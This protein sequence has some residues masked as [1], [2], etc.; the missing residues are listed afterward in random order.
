MTSSS[1]QEQRGIMIMAKRLFCLTICAAFS[2]SRGGGCGVRAFSFVAPAS[3]LSGV[4]S[5]PSTASK[6]VSFRKITISSVGRSPSTTKL[7]ASPVDPV[8]L[9]HMAQGGFLAFAGDV[10]AQNLLSDNND[11]EEDTGFSVL[12]SDWD[13][14]RT[15]AFT[16][17]GTFYTGGAQHFIFAFLNAQFDEPYQRLLLAQFC[18]IPLCYY[19]I[20]LLTVPALRAAGGF[21]FARIFNP[22]AYPEV[23]Q[24]KEELTEQ[25]LGRLPATLV[26]NWAFWLPV[27]F[28]QFA[29]IPKD[30]QVTYC[31]GFGVIWN[32]I[33][34]WSTMSSA[35]EEVSEDEKI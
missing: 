32:V 9:Q 30:L 20:F 7:N 35:D 27:Q 34:S 24:F 13:S 1:P 19:P 25:V 4:S 10:I 8:L 18:F 12:P 33:L 14:S 22:G 26:R 29:F 28:V 6:A 23:A 31:A 15:L 3:R 21:D 16:T 2:G 5:V 11:E 17:F